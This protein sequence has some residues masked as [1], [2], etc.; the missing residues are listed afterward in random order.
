M[1]R[2]VYVVSNR[3]VLVM[4]LNLRGVGEGLLLVTPEGHSYSSTSSTLILPI[5]T[6]GS[7]TLISFPSEGC[8]VCSCV[9]Q[10]WNGR[11][12]GMDLHVYRAMLAR[13]ATCL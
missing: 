12:R 1:I 13:G 5:R 11:E 3:G 9:H 4:L 7:S 6:Y 10:T 8:G 2:E